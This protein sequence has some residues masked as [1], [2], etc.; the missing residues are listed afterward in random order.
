MRAFVVKWWEK[1]AR[2][3]DSDLCLSVGPN[4]FSQE[5]RSEEKGAREECKM[6]NMMVPG[7][8]GELQFDDKRRREG[9]GI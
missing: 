1:S 2:H 8:G 5:N 7:P 4:N 9:R 3:Y 6:Q